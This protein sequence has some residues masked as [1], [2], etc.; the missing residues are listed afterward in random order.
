[1]SILTS[2]QHTFSRQALKSKRKTAIGDISKMNFDALPPSRDPLVAA[3]SEQNSALAASQLN[4][5]PSV[6][7]APAALSADMQGHKLMS[8]DRP[9]PTK[10]KNE[11]GP[12]VKQDVSVQNQNVPGVGAAPLAVQQIRIGDHVDKVRIV[13]DA[14]GPLKYRYDLDNNEKLLIVDLPGAQWKGPASGTGNKSGLVASYNVTPTADGSMLALQLKAETNVL[15]D[16]ILKPS[17]GSGFHRLMIDL[18][19]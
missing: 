14:T 3:R 18:G 12:P 13:I 11:M 4:Y 19:K 17:Q 1:M 5:K 6:T 2:I 7:Q 16:S 9:L 15:K 8:L 10:P